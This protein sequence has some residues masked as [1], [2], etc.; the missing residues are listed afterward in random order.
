MER[1]L[2]FRV[3]NGMNMEYNVTVGKFGVFFV[4]PEKGDGLNPNDSASLTP[5][6]TKYFDNTPVM[7]YTGLKDKNGREIYEGDM[8]N[9]IELNIDENFQFTDDILSQRV[10]EVIWDGDLAGW[11]LKADSFPQGVIPM[12]HLNQFELLGNIYENPELLNS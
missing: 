11:A 9:A 3:W 4:N 12:I 6:T 8:V 10:A 5:N 7:Q 2:K 1:E